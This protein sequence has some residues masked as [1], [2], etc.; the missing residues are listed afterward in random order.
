MKFKNYGPMIILYVGF[1]VAVIGLAIALLPDHPYWI[2]Y[3]ILGT[4][5]EA[6]FYYMLANP[7]KLRWS[8]GGTD[9]SLDRLQCKRYD[10]IRIMVTNLNPS[11]KYTISW[12]PGKVAWNIVD[13]D[14][15]D[16]IPLQDGIHPG[17]VHPGIVQQ[18]R[19]EVSPGFSHVWTW[20][21]DVPPGIYRIIVNFQRSDN[22]FNQA[23][24]RRELARKLCITE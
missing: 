3:L 23:K 22:F 16:A 21:A 1:E 17:V 10:Q 8:H 12:N 18:Q 14:G 13:K 9:W 4:A 20:R 2:Y 11:E 24:D 19:I 15:Q 5:D 6:I 7:Q